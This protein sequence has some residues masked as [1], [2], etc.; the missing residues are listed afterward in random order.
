ME[1]ALASTTDPLN[2][3][4]TPK[5][6]RR[7][8]VSESFELGPTLAFLLGFAFLATLVLLGYELVLSGTL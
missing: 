4:H 3:G 5:P 1:V 7:T 2:R 6:N 8:P